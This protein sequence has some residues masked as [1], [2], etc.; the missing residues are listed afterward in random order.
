MLKKAGIQALR[1]GNKNDRGVDMKITVLV[2]N[3]AGSWKMLAEHGLALL[4]SDGLTSVLVDTGQGG[5][6]LFAN[7]QTLGV[8]PG[9]I[10]HV[11]LSH[12]HFDHTGGLQ[13]LLLRSRNVPVWAHPEIES[14]HNRMEDGFARFTGCHI[15]RSG[16]DL[17]PVQGLTPVTDSLWA[18]EVPLEH[19]DPRF[20]NPPSRL[21][22][23][24]GDGWKPDPFPDDISMVV[25]G[26]RG[27]SVILGC[28][29]AGVVN[30]LEEVSSHFKTRDFHMVLGGMHLGDQ[31]DEFIDRITSE[32]VTR[33]NVERWRPCH[34]TGLKALCAL[35]AK[36]RDVAWAA[37]GTIL[38]A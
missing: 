29:H 19:R 22:V 11:V 32:L 10:D 20:V 15:N 7:M 23:P 37:A 13:K 21:V 4:A 24:D 1:K 5:D 18:V 38:D 2:E 33:F 36:A 12:G 27:L 16:V 28:A 14:A 30:I 35:S 6:A 9:D 31:A 25:K 8:S 3:F 17:R 26:E 34:C